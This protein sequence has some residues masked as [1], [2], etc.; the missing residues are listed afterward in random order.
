M[1]WKYKKIT[2]PDGS[3]Y[4]ISQKAWDSDWARI[5]TLQGN[6]PAETHICRSRYDDNNYLTVVEIPFGSNQIKQISFSS[7]Q[8]LFTQSFLFDGQRWGAIS[9]NKHL[10][11][12][13]ERAS[14]KVRLKWFI[15]K[16]KPA[17]VYKSIKNSQLAWS[18][19]ALYALQENNLTLT[20]YPSETPSEQDNIQD[21]MSFSGVTGTSIETVDRPNKR[22]ELMTY[23][24]KPISVRICEEQFSAQ[25]V[26]A[27]AE[28]IF[29]RL[30]AFHEQDVLVN[31]LK[32]MN[33]VHEFKND[34]DEIHF[35]DIEGCSK[36]S[37]SGARKTWSAG[38]YRQ[39]ERDCSSKTSDMFALGVTFC[40]I[41]AVCPKKNMTPL[42]CLGAL[43]ASK[44]QKAALTREE[45]QRWFELLN[46]SRALMES[47]AHY[48]PYQPHRPNNKLEQPEDDNQKVRRQVIKSF[49]AFYTV[50][51]DKL[52]EFH[53]EA[54]GC[55]FRSFPEQCTEANWERLIS[56]ENGDSLTCAMVGVNSY[57]NHYSMFALWQRPSREKNMIP[58]V[59]ELFQSDSPDII[60]AIN[61][62]EKDV[63]AKKRKVVFSVCKSEINSVDEQEGKA[64]AL[65]LSLC[66]PDADTTMKNNYKQLFVTDPSKSGEKEFSVLD[67]SFLLRKQI[68]LA[69]MNYLNSSQPGW[70]GRKVVKTLI[71]DLLQ[72][73]TSLN[74]TALE[75][76]V[77]ICCKGSFFAGAG[78]SSVEREGS[79]ASILKPIVCGS[80]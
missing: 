17:S 27:I 62:V 79:R 16:N 34:T 69:S 7:D 11:K 45:V 49:L 26:F 29:V 66:F 8:P 78:T 47:V 68:I 54:I 25:R 52:S 51:K 37:G 41:A 55:L 57:L 9:R 19:N 12:T 63:S 42:F 28:K 24:G 6:F 61:T 80:N 36:T 18:F 70:Y 46:T 40:R 35:I 32:L 74:K 58:F 5:D 72:Q 4:S 2:L 30:N 59:N 65:K 22:R 1:W 31:D 14:E 39:E 73:S 43:I 21:D 75:E 15:P 60:K 23:G 64:A 71:K 67:D 56:A 33:I 20:Y 38:Y 53:L 44:E 10:V 13:R 77:G 3:V 50:H 48:Y 76:K